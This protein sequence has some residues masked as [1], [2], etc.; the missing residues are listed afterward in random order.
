M[1]PKK[2]RKRITRPVKKEE[3]LMYTTKAGKRVPVEIPWDWSR[4]ET[5]PVYTVDK[6]IKNLQEESD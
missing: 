2:K 1:E 3:V 5:D 4:S 6:V